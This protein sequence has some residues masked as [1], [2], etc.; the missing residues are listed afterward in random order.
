MATNKQVAG[1]VGGLL[2]ALLVALLALGGGSSP[3]TTTRATTTAPST[4]WPASPNDVRWFAD[5]ASWNRPA[6]ELGRAPDRVQPFARRLWDHAGGDDRAGFWKPAFVDYSVPAYEASTATGRARVFQTSWSEKLFTFG[7]PPATVIPWSPRWKPGTGNDNILLIVDGER[8]WKVAGVGQAAWNCMQLGN[9]VAAN[10]TPDVGEELCVSDVRI[11]ERLLSGSD[12]VDVGKDRG[13]GM[14]KAALVAR[15]EEVR[16][17]AITHALEMTITNTM[18]GAPACDPVDRAPPDVD[19][20]GWFVPPGRQLERANPVIAGCHQGQSFTPA[21]RA[22]TI[23]GGMRFALNVSDDEITDWLD[24]RGYTG[25]LRRTARI[26]AVAMRDYGWIIAE[27]AC[28]GVGIET[29]GIVGPARDLWAELGIEPN[30]TGWPHRDLLDGLATPE[31][32]W[33]V[34]SP[35]AA[36]YAG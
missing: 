8:A 9:I 32:V 15:A 1:G 33:V 35:D 16:A 2:A 21:D 25:P 6:A 26:F 10:S 36:A 7:V 34:D 13:N 24:Q 29:D 5:D 22:R 23:P 27:T 31:R 14:P 28:F 12:G 11:T 18:F 3:P 20:C 17:G 30:G 19:S 4:T